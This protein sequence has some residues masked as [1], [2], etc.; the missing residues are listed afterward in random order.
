MGF[1]IEKNMP[2]ILEKTEVLLKRS[3]LGN[4]FLYD[5]NDFDKYSHA[6]LFTTENINGYFDNINMQDKD[7][8]TV[9]GSGDHILNAILKGAKKIDAF[10]ISVYAIMLY[11]LKEAAI[12]TLEYEEFIEYFIKENNLNNY[13]IYQKL[14]SKLRPEALIFWDFVYQ[15]IDATK[16]FDSLLFRI[17]MDSTDVETTLNK[18]TK[19][20]RYLE[21]NN[22]YKLKKLIE[23]CEVNCYCRDCKDL[24]EIMKT[25]D[26]MFFSN[27]IQYQQGEDYIKFRQAM[28]RY[29]GKLKEKGAIKVGYIYGYLK[30]K[31][32][33]PQECEIERVE[34]VED[35]FDDYDY[36]LT[37][38]K[39]K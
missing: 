11:Y 36:V 20:S 32:D 24:D 13:Q 4:Y 37:L 10:D 9:V 3:V 15:N 7:I 30:H 31:L 17:R 18:K 14:R 12:K 26:Y 23:L 33:I 8:L 2:E 1:S 22:Y 19:L 34:A 38:R 25:Y 35:F 5:G 27:I 39:C 28:M 16:I 6:Y 21:R 29:L